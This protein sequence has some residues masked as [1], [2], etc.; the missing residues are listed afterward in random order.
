MAKA[1][2]QAVRS[3]ELKIQPAFH[4]ATWYRWLD[5]IR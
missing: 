5:N 4:E 1:A 3:G 2:V